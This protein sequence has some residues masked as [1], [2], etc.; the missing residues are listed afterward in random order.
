MPVVSVHASPFDGLNGWIKRAEDLLI[1]SCLLAAAALPMAAIALT[2]LA[3]SGRPVLFR[4]RR[5]GLN[6]KVVW[7]L[8]FRTMSAADD[9]P[10]LAQARRGDARVTRVGQFLR[11]AS[12]DEL[13]QL[14]NV[15]GGA[16]SLVGPRPHAIA[17]NEAYR[18]L[19]Q[20]YM[21]RHK[22]KPGITG[23]AQVNGWR[24]ETDT[25]DKMQSRIEHDLAYVRDWSLALD[26]Q[27][28]ASTL[29]AVLSRRNAY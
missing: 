19:I 26:L 28:L 16:M 8:K 20:G 2:L 7:V 24:G 21:L 27:I 13:P 10:A 29:R 12:L 18:G 17:H 11:A 5:Y 22:V 9:G 15:L 14:F 23:W 6:G 4:Q 25:L 3:T 1:G